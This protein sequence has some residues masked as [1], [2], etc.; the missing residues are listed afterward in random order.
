MDNVLGA[1][2]AGRAEG[3]WAAADTADAGVEAIDADFER[4]QDVRQAGPTRAMRVE[5]ER[6]AGQ[7]IVKARNTS[8]YKA[9]MGHAGRVTKGDLARA[10]A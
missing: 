9:R 2:V 7:T 4:R 1:D 8:R 10:E 3:K 5:P 6:E